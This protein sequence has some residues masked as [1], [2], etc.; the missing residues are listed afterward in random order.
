MKKF[1][2]FCTVLIVFLSTT[3][4]QDSTAVQ[5]SS[6]VEWNF[7]IALISDL[8]IPFPGTSV[9]WGQTFTKENNLVLEYELGFALPTVVTGKFGI[10]KKINETKVTAG[11]R[12]FPLNLYIQSSFNPKEKGY[13]ICSLE[14]NP[15]HVAG[16]SVSLSKMILNFGFRWDR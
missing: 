2:V 4:A 9:L 15:L 12:P 5:K 10:G 16:E 14:V 7:G 6:F 3:A 11:V 8:S 13:W 1:L